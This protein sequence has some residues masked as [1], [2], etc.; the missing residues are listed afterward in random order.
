MAYLIEL[1]E[2]QT[3][4]TRMLNSVWLILM[5]GSLR[6]KANVKTQKLI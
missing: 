4:K 1:V 5:I 2:G 3:V 6:R